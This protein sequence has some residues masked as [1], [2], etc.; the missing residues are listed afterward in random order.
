MHSEL[1]PAHNFQLRFIL[2][3][4]IPSQSSLD[5]PCVLFL[6]FFCKI[7]Y[8]PFKCYSNHTIDRW[9]EHKGIHPQRVTVVLLPSYPSSATTGVFLGRITSIPVH[10]SLP[11]PPPRE[12]ETCTV[13]QLDLS[14]SLATHTTKHRFALI[15]YISELV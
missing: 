11:P 7:F 13:L 12:Y 15:H 2:I 1:N 6:K 3:L 9:S 14:S 10:I 8:L 5:L 4:L